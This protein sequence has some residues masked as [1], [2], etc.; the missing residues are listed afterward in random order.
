MVH[1]RSS[2]AVVTAVLDRPVV[3]G[4]GEGQAALGLVTPEPR[5]SS[6]PTTG[7]RGSVGQILGALDAAGCDVVEGRRHL[8]DTASWCSSAQA[9]R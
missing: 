4:A 8:L 9:S 3:G 7:E 5:R 6:R 1:M 2:H